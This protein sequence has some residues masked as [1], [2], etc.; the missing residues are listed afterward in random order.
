MSAEPGKLPASTTSNV[1]T[2]FDMAE[3]VSRVIPPEERKVDPSTIPWPEGIPKRWETP[4]PP[5][6]Q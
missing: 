5:P 1:G 6:T 3:V 4:K 2:T